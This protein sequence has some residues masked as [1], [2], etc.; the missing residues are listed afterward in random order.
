M[1]KKLRTF[2][3]CEEAS[4]LFYDLAFWV[5]API[6]FIVSLTD[7][8]LLTVKISQ[9]RLKFLPKKQTNLRF[10]GALLETV[11]GFSFRQVFGLFWLLFDFKD[12]GAYTKVMLPTNFESKIGSKEP[13]NR[14]KVNPLT[15]S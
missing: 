3:N 1:R 9:F 11:N 2:E 14:Q 4:R 10:V 7:S 15:V 13:K 8:E 5:V 6:G 12:W